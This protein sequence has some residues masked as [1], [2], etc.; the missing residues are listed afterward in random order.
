LEI[1][2]KDQCKIFVVVIT[3]WNI[4]KKYTCSI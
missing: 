4:Y 3:Y 2:N 1:I